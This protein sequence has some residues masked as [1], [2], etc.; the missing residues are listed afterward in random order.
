MSHHT[1]ERRPEV[2]HGKRTPLGH[3][4]DCLW[5]LGAPCAKHAALI[6]RDMDGA[7][8]LGLRVGL[9]L[10]LLTCAPCR[11]LASQWAALR[12][13][14][15]RA[16]GSLRLPRAMPSDVRDRIARAVA[17]SAGRRANDRAARCDSPDSF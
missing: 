2:R 9:R 7:L 16:Q 17:Q 14:V 4:R 10:H 5:V 8:P 1:H 13:V 12:A 15:G 3:V 6:S 11:H